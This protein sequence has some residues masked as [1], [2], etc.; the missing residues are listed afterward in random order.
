VLPNIKSFYLV[1]FHDNYNLYMLHHICQLI[2]S[3]LH[4]LCNTNSADLFRDI[5][6]YFVLF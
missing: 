4:Y 5:Y 6:L 3:I 2:E 1:P